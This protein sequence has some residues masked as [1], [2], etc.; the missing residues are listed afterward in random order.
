MRQAERTR[1]YLAN[2]FWPRVIYTSPLSHCARTDEI[3]AEPYAVATSPLPAFTDIDC[4]EWQGK[5][6]GE[7]R[8]AEPAAF[9]SWR[10]TPHL[11]AIPGGESL[12]RVAA[13]V[14]C[15]MRIIPAQHRGDTDFLVG[16]DSVNRVLLLL[17]LDLPLS[18]FWHLQQDPCATN[19]LDH[20]GADG[21]IIQSINETAHLTS[22]TNS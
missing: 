11:A 13:R 20:D 3:I 22:A 12:Y 5:S 21:W 9:T 14:A 2:K 16:H 8:A 15:V 7:V 17:A 10:G 4:G 18:R 19:I 1:D 6:Y